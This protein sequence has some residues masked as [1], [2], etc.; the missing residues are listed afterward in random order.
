MKEVL[1]GESG[2][3][4]PTPLSMEVLGLSL[5]MD[6]INNF[7]QMYKLFHVGHKKSLCS[8][9]QP[10]GH[11]EPACCG[12]SGVLCPD[13]QYCVPGQDSSSSKKKKNRHAGHIKHNS[14][15]L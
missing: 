3:V 10:L 6:Q 12:S 15:L 2:S 13:A 14:Y 1:R 11:A 9:A 4:S 5:L 8:K 7:F